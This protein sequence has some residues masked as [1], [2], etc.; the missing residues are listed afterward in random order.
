[1]V[2]QAPR[3][4]SVWR[5]LM[6]LAAVLGP[7]FVTASAGNDVGGIATYSSAGAQFGYNIIW[8]MVPLAVALIVVQEMSTRMGCVTG[9]GLAALIRENF[10]VKISVVAMFVLF[11]TNTLIT[12]T[13]FAGIAAAAENWGVSRYVAVPVALVAVFFF[14]L[15]LNGK[16]VERT[17]VVF[18][19]VYLTYI[20]S[21]VLAHPN[22]HDVATGTLLPH[23]A[24]STPGWLVMVITIIGT[25][26][27]PY[28]Q[29]FLQSQVVEKGSRTEDLP[30]ARADVINGSILAIALAGFMMI[31][32]AATIFLANEHGA[33]LNPQQ[34]MD[35]AVALKP[36][37]GAAASTIFALGIL[38][39]GLFTATVLPLSTSY[40]VCEA[41][42]FEAAVDRKFS[43]APVFFTLFAA[44]LIIG[45]GFV[46]IPGLPLLKLILFAQ[47]LQG[48]LLPFELILMLVI[49]NRKHVM[50]KHT[51]S[52]TAN[53]I[54]WAT[55]IVIGALSLMSVLAQFIPQLGGG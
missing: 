28:M 49:I 52:V 1:M 9:K 40:I 22:W 38:N 43:E 37:A 13:E 42:G 23:F 32:N 48:V 55:T 25:T 35:F 31:A 21:A 17:F 16:T 8:V 10:G 6:L 41:L 2:E 46:L 47:A 33:K 53:V 4:R 14:V 39:A 34:A 5:T 50:G 20:V 19:L 44:G 18:S 12:S 26:I 54:A 36:L 29:F 3:R 51:N 27:S 24:L 11:L 7:G 45:A 30:L 15:R